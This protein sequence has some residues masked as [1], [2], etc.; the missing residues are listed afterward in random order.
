[1]KR[2]YIA[3]FLLAMVVAACFFTQRYQHRQ[4]K[5]MLSAIDYIEAQYR[6]DNVDVALAEA[7]QFAE[8]YRVLSNRISCYIA[9]GELQES[10]ETAALLPT[11]IEEG[12]KDEL[13]E[14]IARLRSQLTYLEQIDDPLL[15]NIL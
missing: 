6:A 4:V 13:F 8:E 11:L 12:E 7:R 9:H 15:Q 1:M 14:E 3:V 10:R 5:R 2:L